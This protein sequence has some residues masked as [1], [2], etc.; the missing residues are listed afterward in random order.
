MYLISKL[1]RH[2]FWL[3]DEVAILTFRNNLRVYLPFRPTR[4]SALL[5][6]KLH[7]SMSLQMNEF[8]FLH[9]RTI[10]MFGLQLYCHKKAP[11]TVD[12]S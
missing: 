9:L 12:C 7:C 2:E 6:T 4:R 11:V 8:N 5:R 10:E 3:K 1:R